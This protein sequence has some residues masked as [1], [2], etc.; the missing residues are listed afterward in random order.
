MFLCFDVGRTKTTFTIFLI[1][2][3]SQ[4][5]FKNLKK[6]TVSVYV[7]NP[8]GSSKRTHKNKKRD[9]HENKSFLPTYMQPI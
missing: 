4:I 7:G 6:Y 3:Q 5:I 1:I 9:N 2:F 8:R